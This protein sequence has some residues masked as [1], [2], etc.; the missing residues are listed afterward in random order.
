[1]SA[2]RF[3]GKPSDSQAIEQFLGNA[4]KLPQR[5]T[6]KAFT[7]GRLLFAL[8]ATASRQPSWDRAC[9]LQGKM[10]TAT[11]KLGGLQLQLCYYR[12]INE[13]HYSPWIQDSQSLL[14][15]MSAVHCLGGY[16]QLGRVLNHALTEHR[17]QSLQAVIIIADAVEEKVDDLCAKAGKLGMLGLPLFMFQEGNDPTVRQCFQQMASLSKG[18]YATFDDQ[19]ATHLAEL[20]AA[21]ATFASGG[22]DALSRLST[23]A[24]RHLLQ[25]LER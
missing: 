16:T 22:Q 10:F 15:T 17:D 8:D 7:K 23:G 5:S 2:D 20:L 3:P 14:K 25:Q 9:H 19:S 24:A 4:S 21:V 12:G 1:M 18:A 13:F 11:D 6:S